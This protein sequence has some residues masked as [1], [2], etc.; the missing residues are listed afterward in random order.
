MLKLAV[1]NLSRRKTR[2]ILTLLGITIA[3]SFTVGLL[4]ISEGFLF[5]FDKALQMRGEDIFVLPEEVS[6]HPMP[7]MESYGSRFSQ[8]K[9]KEI[10]K[11]ENVK[12]VY[13]I[14]TQTLYFAHKKGESILEGFASLN[15]VTPNFFTD[16]RPFLEIDKGRFLKDGDEYRVVVGFQ[17]AQSQNLNV[18][19]DLQIRKDFFEVVGI[20]KKSGGLEDM[21]VYVP[22]QTLQKVYQDEG[23]LTIAAVTVKD[24]NK[25]KET[26]KNISS[27]IPNISARTVEELTEMMTDLLSMA[28]A[29]HLSVS[30]IALLIGTLFILSTMLM[31]VSERVKEIGTM[32]AIGAH[33]SQIFKLI[34]LESLFISLLGGFLGLIGGYILS[35]GITYILSEVVDIS[36]FTPLISLR[37]LLFGFTISVLMGVFAGFFPAL[38]ISKTNIIEALH[39]E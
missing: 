37:I 10:K 32:R 29:I 19:D 4:S 5:S 21:L 17:V 39:H 33:S 30:S 25:L 34:I 38:K 3:I 8:D 2:T 22:I 31:A 13:P 1:K 14:Y 24:I 6:G 28:R 23:K 15:G 9:I 18:G 11:I 35:Q 36:F 20:L 16:L 7:M 12:N 27:E 26:A